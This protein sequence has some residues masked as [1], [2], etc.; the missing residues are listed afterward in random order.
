MNRLN[1]SVRLAAVVALNV[2]ALAAQA[3]PSPTT[4]LVLDPS[5]RA[6]TLPNGMHY[7]VRANAT[8][9]KRAELRLAV[10]AGSIVEDD[11]QRGM[12]HVIEHMA[13]NGTTHFQKNE[14]VNYLQSIGVRFG[15]DLNAYTS[16]DET[17][18]MLQV[19][20]D[21]ARIVEQGITVLED[22]AHGQ[23]FDST[24]VANER[25]VVVEEWRL[26]KGAGDRM[27]QQ[28]W[29]V[30][31]RGSRYADRWIIGTQESILSSTPA[32]L[33]RF[34]RD[35]YRP[36]LM[37][38]VAVGDFDAAQMEALIKKHF[39]GI[40]PVPNARKRVLAGVPPNK[41]PLIA[42]TSD[43]EATNTT[44]QLMFK[45]PKE[46]ARTV[47][48]YRT[49][50]MS[51]LYSTMLNARLNEVAQRP[52]AP[53]AQAFG[54]KGSFVRG[55]D[56][57]NVLALVKDGGAERGAEA[58]ITEARRIDQFGFLQSELDRAKQNTLRSYER[59]YVERGRT[60]SSQIVNQYVA[61]FLSGEPAPGV[62]AEYQLVQQLLPGIELQD[63]NRLASEWITDENRV[64]IVQGPDKPG[65]Q[66]PTRD[67]MLAVIDRA[68]KAPVATYAEHV[69]TDALIATLPTAGKV[70]S[71]RQ[72]KDVGITE[73]ILSNGARVLV[74]PTDFK[75]D[76]IRFAA[77]SPGGTSLVSDAD[78]MSA[79]MS[80]QV[81]FASGVGNVSRGDLAK[82]LSGKSVN[83]VPNISP[84]TE[85]LN[86]LASP[87]DLE[88]LLQL[89]Y[90]QFTAPRLD[91][92][93]VAAVK[94]Q[95]NTLLANQGVSPER[96]V[97]DTFTT[98]MASNHLRARPINS[99]TLAEM[100]PQRAY[101]IYRDR[102]SDA[103][104][105]T[106]VFV[107]NVDTV[108]L[109]PLAEQ[110]LASLPSTRR[111]ETWRDVG[112]RAPTGII[113]KVVRKGSEP[114]SVTYIAFSGPIDYSEQNRFDLQ[115]LVEV[116]RIKLIETLREKMSGTYSP[117]IS[118]ASSKIPIPQYSITTFFSSSPENV[119]PLS[120]AVFAVIDSLQKNG[121]LQVDVDKVKEE[122]IRAHEVELKQN[123]YW[124]SAI[125][126]RDQNGDDLAAS[127]AQ[128]DAMVRSLT[129]SEIQQAAKQY[130]NVKN[131][132]RVVL[133]PEGQ[134][135]TP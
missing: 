129:A 24:E 33:R 18:Y 103:S 25:G 83:L 122:L 116:V 26:G 32:L 58:L 48:E 36:D 5:V 127:L 8:P 128:F 62:E 3:A 96:A 34:Y 69:S 49:R 23:L 16:F 20:T 13:F 119:E 100:N 114:K 110:Y 99:A 63:V 40:Q 44:V 35:W 61:N 132:V 29:P 66:M 89:A 72:M 59:A 92:V 117:G 118:S 108:A 126:S 9:A 57:F 10:N 7:F 56:V 30:M 11:D 91:T 76:E 112:I 133:M 102:F 70:M 109:K 53:F 113:E 55:L 90:L 94:A 15:A 54:N 68:S 85:G 39:S 42:I 64:I 82:R 105:F 84:T 121:P 107:G 88:T 27:R 95:L 65:V 17:V 123:A 101:D 21:T 125:Q 120:R 12:A 31:F 6:G 38:V 104:D 22:W 111:K 134:K 78:F 75:A 80:A 60:P 74:K 115:A 52:D 98:T 79:V 124:M 131:Y 86:G 50:L 4:P 135:V 1:W 77:Y 43:K 97:A 93:A 51:R 47:G 46:D 106:F 2:G 19:P 37:A 130:F 67:A 71:G 81:V 45:L 73:W 41:E 14:L 87:K 28:Y